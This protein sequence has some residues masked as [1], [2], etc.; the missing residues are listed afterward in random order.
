MMVFW[1]TGKG[2][3]TPVILF[4]VLIAFGVLLQAGRLLLKDEPWFWGVA[5][6]VAGGVN[7]L[8][9]RRRNMRKI[10]AVR[11]TRFRDTLIYRARNKFMSL[12]LETWSIPLVVGGVGTIAFGFAGV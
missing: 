3:L 9:G 5:F 6:V 4:A 7:W 8:I 1:W 11:S 12:P 2:Y 10:A